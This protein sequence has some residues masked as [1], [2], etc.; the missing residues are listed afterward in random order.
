MIAP[1]L[2]AP[3]LQSSQMAEPRIDL[4]SSHALAHLACAT[5]PRIGSTAVTNDFIRTLSSPFVAP[6]PAA[7]PIPTTA[8]TLDDPTSP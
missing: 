7:P 3:L 4:P 5:A 6:T 1:L 8:G 2:H